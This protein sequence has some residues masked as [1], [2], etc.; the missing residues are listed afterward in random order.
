MAKF[1]K[2]CGKEINGGLCDCPQAAAEAAGQEQNNGNPAPGAQ[3][4]GAQASEIVSD[5]KQL[6]IG[7]FTR[8]V[9]T[10]EEAALSAN[11]LPQYLM[12]AV[13]TIVM[14]FYVNIGGGALK[15]FGIESGDLFRIGFM[16]A[17][18]MLAVR[19]VYAAA[20]FALAKKCNPQLTLQ[21]ALG[22]FSL[23]FLFDAAIAVVQLLLSV[24]HLYEVS[25]GLSLFWLVLGVITAFL[26]A[27]KLTKE[28]MEAAFQI[29]MLLQLIFLIVL[30]FIVRGIGI[31]IMEA[32]VDEMMGS[33][34]GLSGL[35]QF[36]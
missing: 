2:Y 24:I 17:L 35:G 14:M 7:M 28:N 20:V 25:I 4:S 1:C 30:V 36:Y 12:A 22:V 6:F 33:L 10:I 13:F 5:M 18:G 11:K 26:A 16:T 15:E 31:S 3:I 9:Q 21:T 29:T 19:A 34:G 8:P 23:M 32:I 27:W